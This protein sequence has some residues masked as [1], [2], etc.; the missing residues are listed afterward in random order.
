ME[1][2][3]IIKAEIEK[4]T[5]KYIRI[6]LIVLLA[7]EGLLS[8]FCAIGYGR[9]ANH[10]KE[11]WHVWSD[12]GFYCL[13]FIIIFGVILISLGI[14]YFVVNHMELIVTNK[15]VYGKTTFGKRVDLPIDSISSTGLCYFNGIFIASSSGKIKFLLMK[16]RSELHNVISELVIGRQDNSENS[17]KNVELVNKSDKLN[18]SADEIR[19]YKEL[20]D[21]GVVTQEEFD[22]K[23]KQLLG[24]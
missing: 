23:K 9:K 6:F 2:K 18:S 11:S 16:N 12:V 1:E 5:I 21:S 20:L 22:A 19:K 3:E 17:E 7:I 4:R 10:Y 8:I 13:V 15:R 24:L 14:F